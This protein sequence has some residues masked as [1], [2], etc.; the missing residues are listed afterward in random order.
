[1]QPTLPAS[2]WA[3]K[4]RIWAVASWSAAPE[5][6]GQAGDKN[7]GAAVA[8]QDGPLDQALSRF[9]ANQRDSPARPARRARN[10]RCLAL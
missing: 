7:A 3:V 9:E 2:E 8:R 6:D 4:L 5:G 10:Q 1:M